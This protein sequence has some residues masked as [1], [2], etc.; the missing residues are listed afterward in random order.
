VAGP[1]AVKANFPNN[2]KD[3]AL[4]GREIDKPIFQIVISISDEH[5]LGPIALR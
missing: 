1:W 3:L 5:H 2:H 4:P